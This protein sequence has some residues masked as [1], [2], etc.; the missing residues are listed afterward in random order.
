MNDVDCSA[1]QRFDSTPVP[2]LGSAHTGCQDNPLFSNP[3]PTARDGWKRA[4]FS[5]ISKQQNAFGISLR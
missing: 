3:R 1:C 2:A 5:R 4:Y